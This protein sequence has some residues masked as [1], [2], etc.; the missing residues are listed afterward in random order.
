LEQRVERVVGHFVAQRV[1]GEV[2]RFLALG[3]LD[4]V[5]H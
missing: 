5:G 4:P 2:E 1:A 3:V